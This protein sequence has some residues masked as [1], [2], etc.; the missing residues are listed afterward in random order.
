MKKIL[1][2]DDSAFAR[3]HLKRSL[4]DSY[5]YLEAGDGLSGI[6]AYFLHHP[7]LVIL[8]ITMP[9]I[10]G[11]DALEKI[12]EIDPQA[13]VIICSADVQEYSRIKANELGAAGFISKPI[14]VDHLNAIVRAILE[15]SGE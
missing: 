5:E 13:K 3:N 10:S 15:N 14:L 6:E 11:L 12:H 2:I 7:D 9:G 1:L 8:D 4:G